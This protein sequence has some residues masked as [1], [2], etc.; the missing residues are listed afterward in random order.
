MAEKK[1]HELLKTLGWI[2]AFVLV[3]NWQSVAE[4][5]RGPVD[6]VAEEAGPVTVYGTEWCGYCK[7]TK[8]FLRTRDIPFKERDIEKSA[9][10]YD[11]F[12]RLGGRGVPVVTVG[13]QV[14][15]GYNL[16]GL[17]AALECANCQP[18]E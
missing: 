18:T 10:A 14:V 16:R 9:P 11:A 4:T 1:N 12:Q 3:F 8:R 17:R 7:R 2:G 6:Y 15:H 5:V 13:D